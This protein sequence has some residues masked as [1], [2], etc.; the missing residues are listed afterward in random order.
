MLSTETRRRPGRPAKNQAPPPAE[1]APL[2]PTTPPA[3][4]VEGRLYRLKE[5]ASYPGR[6]GPIGLSAPTIWAHCNPKVGRFPRPVRLG[7]NS[8][9]WKGDDLRRWMDSLSPDGG[10]G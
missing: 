5:I 7:P 3:F 2:P 10:N 1:P 8:V 6:P 4:P 9:A